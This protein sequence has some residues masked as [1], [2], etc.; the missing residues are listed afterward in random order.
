MSTNIFNPLQFFEKSAHFVSQ[1]RGL[2]RLTKIPGVMSTD[3]I[4]VDDV[5]QPAW[6]LLSNGIVCKSFDIPGQ[7][8]AT[9][10]HAFMGPQRKIGYGVLFSDIGVEFL[11]MNTKREDAACL[12]RFFIDWQKTIAPP[13]F[14]GTIADT[15]VS[16]DTSFGVE[17]YDK[18]VSEAEAT[19]YTPASTE[20]AIKVQYTELFPTDVGSLKVGWEQ[21][22][23]PMTLTI[24]FAYHY[25]KL[26]TK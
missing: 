10:D 16:Q 1:G 8:V 20:P 13:L 17:Y 26:V 15:P 3:T 21:S 9:F 7:K 12:Y 18:Y 4:F 22:D 19:I 2:F 25:S 23:A 14:D 24:N 5:Y 11:L 6:D